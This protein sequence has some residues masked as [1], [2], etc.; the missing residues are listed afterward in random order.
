MNSLFNLIEDDEG[1]YR[2]IIIKYKSYFCHTVSIIQR[3]VINLRD[4]GARYFD[5]SSLAY[6]IDD[7]ETYYRQLRKYISIIIKFKKSVFDL[8]YFGVRSFI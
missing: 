2:K 6:I 1:A 7:E 5:M 8:R 3:S 4:Y